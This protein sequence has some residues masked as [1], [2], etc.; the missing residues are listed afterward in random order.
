M[1]HSQKIFTLYMSLRDALARAVAGIVPPKEIEDIVQ[2]TYV[3]ACKIDNLDDIKTPRAFLFKTARNLALDYIK[4]AENRLIINIE[5][6]NEAYYDTVKTANN[7]TFEEVATNEE[8]ALF[9]EAVRHLPT[10]TRRVFVLKKVY[11]HTQKEIAQEMNLSEST[12]EKHISLGIKR[13]TYF[14]MQYDNNNN[15]EVLNKSAKNKLIAS[16]NKKGGTHE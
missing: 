13:C 15:K 4:K 14:M 6:E 5:T 11:G 3:R 16:S 10:Q 12:I 1:P 2:E 7:D 8:F 9:C